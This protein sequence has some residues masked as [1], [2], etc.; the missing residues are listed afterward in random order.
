M[1]VLVTGASSGIGQA[2]ALEFINWGHK[3]IGIDVLP[4]SMK[5]SNYTHVEADVSNMDELP[6]IK[7]VDILINNAGVQNNGRDIEVNLIGTMNCTKKYGIRPGIRAIVNVASTS[8][9]TGAE[10][11]EYAASKGGVLAYTKH[12][13]MEVAKFGA[14][15][16]SVSPGGVVTPINQHILDDP[17][18]MS[19]V[20]KETMLGKWASAKEIAQWI[21]FIAAVNTSMTGQDIIIDNGETSK[22]NFIW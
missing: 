13:A 6:T 18:L 17:E 2:T 16:N 21:F 5:H 15:C 11:P 12:V 9:H 8:G 20:L 14:T 10:F 7:Y 22:Y 4:A 19:A 3:V 1:N